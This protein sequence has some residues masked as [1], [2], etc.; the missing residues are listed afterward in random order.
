V[1]P[2]IWDEEAVGKRVSKSIKEVLKVVK[3]R[4]I[5]DEQEQCIKKFKL[6]EEVIDLFSIMQ[7]VTL[8]QDDRKMINAQVCYYLNGIIMGDLAKRFGISRELS[9]YIETELLKNYSKE[10][11]VGKVKKELKDRAD[12]CV[13]IQEAE[14]Y[15]VYTKDSALNKLKEIGIPWGEEHDGVT[16]IKGSV[17][18][19][20][21]YKGK[22]RVLKSS[23]GVEDFEEGCVIVTGMTTPDFVPLMKKAGA[24][25]TDE[26]GITSHAAIVSRELDLPCI[27]GTKIA[28]KVLKDGDLVEVDADKGIVRIIERK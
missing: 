2:D 12:F 3:E 26:G 1:G 28:T 10:G 19:R 7:T 11:D 22:V 27:I 16:E 21:K 23:S 24:I 6:K 13:I 20:G 4:D 15:K 18:N 9:L 25:V 14:K 8:M 17:A 5:E